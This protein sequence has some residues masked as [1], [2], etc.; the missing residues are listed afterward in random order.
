MRNAL[1]LWQK[2]VFIQQA[3]SGHPARWG[4]TFI[5]APFNGKLSV[6]TLIIGVGVTHGLGQHVDERQSQGLCNKS[7]IGEKEQNMI[8]KKVLAQPRLASLSL[9]VI[10]T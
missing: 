7:L 3:L 5:I 10:V 4:K 1:R 2:E 8:S 6:W 9:C